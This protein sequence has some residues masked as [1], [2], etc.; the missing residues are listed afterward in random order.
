MIDQQ[1]TQTHLMTTQERLDEIAAILAIAIIRSLKRTEI[2]APGES[3]T[4]LHCEAKHACNK[5]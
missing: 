3:F 5:P 2:N 4:G 1:Q